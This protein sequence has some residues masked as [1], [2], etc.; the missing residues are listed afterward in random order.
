[1][2]ALLISGAASGL[3]A[4]RMQQRDAAKAAV[5]GRGTV[6]GASSSAGVAQH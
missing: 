3:G 2:L 6:P 1:M 4:Q 5:H